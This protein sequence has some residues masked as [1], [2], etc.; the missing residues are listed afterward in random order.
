MN[1][2]LLLI[3]G[4]PG[5]GKTTIASGYA[6]QGYVHLEADMYF[7]RDG[8]Y[9]FNPA[10]L[11]KAHDWCASEVRKALAEGRSVVVANTFSRLW[12]FEIYTESAKLYDVPVRI[13]E[14]TGNFQN[15]HNVPPE[16]VQK[17]RERWENL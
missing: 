10:L 9:N 16:V 11:G 17:M 3:R 1:Q 6:R 14:A 5:S 13:I 2:E 7:E 15:I 8:E 12:E 4:L